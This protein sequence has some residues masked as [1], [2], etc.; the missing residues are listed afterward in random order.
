MESGSH[1]PQQARSRKTME[2]LLTATLAVIEAKGLAGVTVPEIAAAA[3]MS[4]GSVYRR[5]TD[6]DALIRLAFLRLLESSQQVNRTA[7]P[8]DRFKG[9]RLD[10]ALQ[11]LASG[12]VAQYRRRT[13]LL[14]ALDQYLDAHCDAAFQEHAVG[15]IEANLKLVTVALLPFRKQ[16][17]A[18]D[19]EKAIT[20]ALLS[21]ITLIE[22]H[23][24]H[25][26]PVWQRILPLDDKALAAETARTMAAYLSAK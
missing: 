3:K 25:N 19:P 21:A 16:I 14:K 1:T 6:K 7:L 22:A 20:F 8:P 11:K 12:L 4:T 24:L 17:A 13:G 18:T 23:K 26:S 2:K 5:F 9:L 15:V 10:Q